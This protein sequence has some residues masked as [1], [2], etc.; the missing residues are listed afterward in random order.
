M[1]GKVLKMEPLRKSHLGTFIHRITLKDTEE[2]YAL[3]TNWFAEHTLEIG[4]LVEYEPSLNSIPDEYGKLV[5]WFDRLRVVDENRG[6]QVEA[7][8]DL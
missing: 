8:P 1:K 6:E 3:H 5:Y 7:E 2:T 4:D